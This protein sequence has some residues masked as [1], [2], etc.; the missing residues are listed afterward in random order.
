MTL[1]LMLSMRKWSNVLIKYGLEKPGHSY[2]HIL[3]TSGTINLKLSQVSPI[4]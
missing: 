3:G 4:D 1:T 2:G